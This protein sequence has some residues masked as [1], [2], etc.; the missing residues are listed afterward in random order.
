MSISQTRS[1]Q[2]NKQLPM[3][4]EENSTH[5][6]VRVESIDDLS[7]SL[8]RRTMCAFL[9]TGRECTM[10]I[11]V[12]K[13]GVVRGVKVQKKEVSSSKKEVGVV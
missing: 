2:L 11:G 3:C 7:S 1:Y 5:S 9:N 4:S 8:V 13:D 10:H 6:F 12:D